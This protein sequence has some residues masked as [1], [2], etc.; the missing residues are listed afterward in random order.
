MTDTQR[1]IWYCLLLVST[2]T[3]LISIAAGLFV[4]PGTS[5]WQVLL[6][7]IT[8]IALLVNVVILI[9]AVVKQ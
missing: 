9:D 4:D 3:T 1:G 5:I 2:A 8:A 6:P 7:G